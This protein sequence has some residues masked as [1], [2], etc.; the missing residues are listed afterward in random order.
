MQK[1]THRP[2]Y[3]FL[4]KTRSS[5]VALAG[6]ELSYVDQAGF[7]LRNP[8]AFVFWVLGLKMCTGL[9]LTTII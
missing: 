7:K 4:F 1:Y 5:S 2:N 3:F 9:A 6:L 8:P